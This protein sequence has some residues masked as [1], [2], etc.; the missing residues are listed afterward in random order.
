MVRSKLLAN[1]LVSL[2]V[3]WKGEQGNPFRSQQASNSLNL[4]A[5]NV[6][7]SANTHTGNQSGM[8]ILLSTLWQKGKQQFN[9]TFIKALEVSGTILKLCI[10]S[11]SQAGLIL[12]NKNRCTFLLNEW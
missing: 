2:R 11:I 7:P 6:S 10:N 12:K 9:F 4:N 5:H 3:S 8:G 1:Y